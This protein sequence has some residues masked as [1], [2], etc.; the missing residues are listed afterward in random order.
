MHTGMDFS[1]N[2]GTPIQVTANGKVAFTGW[3]T[4]YGWTIVVRHTPELETL[5]AHL[6][7]I[8]VK[9]G[10]KVSRGDIIG[11]MGRSG[12]STGPHLH[13]EVRSFGRHVSPKPYLRLQRQWIK[14]LR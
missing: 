11:K 3:Q 5:Y 8:D 13:Y 7:H 9:M 6:S 1:N 10:Q 12:R 14:S 2:I 4:N